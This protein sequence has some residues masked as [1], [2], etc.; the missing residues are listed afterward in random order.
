[1]LTRIY[2]FEIDQDYAS[3]AASIMNSLIGN[4]LGDDGPIVENIL[5]FQFVPSS[6]FVIVDSCH[7]FDKPTYEVVV[8]CEVNWGD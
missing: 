2:S 8:L 5:H 1:M 3:D 4:P 7:D 6:R